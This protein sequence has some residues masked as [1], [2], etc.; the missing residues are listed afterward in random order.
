MIDDL[1][2]ATFIFGA[3]GSGKTSISRALADASRPRWDTAMWQEGRA[4]DV[5]VY[6]KDFAN[7]VIESYSRLEGVFLLGG[8]S[9]D[10]HD[11]LDEIKSPQGRQ[12]QVMRRREGCVKNLED[13]KA[14]LDVARSTFESSVWSKKSE[15][16]TALE[17]AFKGYN[18]AKD[19]FARQLLTEDS[20]TGGQT[21]DEETLLREASSIFDS[22]TGI[23]N[24]IP[25]IQTLDATQIR[26]CAMLGTRIVG[27]ADAR[28]SDLVD[29]LKN[30]DWVNQ[31]RHYLGHAKGLC[32]FC[33]QEVP[34]DLAAALEELFDRTYEDQKQQLTVFI[35]E[36]KSTAGDIVTAAESM[37]ATTNKFIDGDKLFA[38]VAEL[39][40]ADLAARTK[41]DEKFNS[42]ANGFELPNLSAQID[43]VNEVIRAANANI[44]D[45]NDRIQQ[46]SQKHPLLVKRCWRYFAKTHASSEIAVYTST[47]ARLRPKIEGL[48]KSL[49]AADEELDQISLRIQALEAQMVSSAEV[50]TRINRLLVNT[51][52]SS[53][54]LAPSSEVKDGYTMVRE[55][56]VVE[57]GTLSEGEST[58][59][60]FLYFYY[61]VE[62][63][64]VDDATRPLIVVIDDPISSM[65][66][67]AMLV[68]SVLVKTLVERTK[69]PSS[70]ISQVIVLTH[71][72]HFHKEV[73]YRR[74]LNADGKRIFYIIRKFADAPH[75]LTKHE[76]NPIQSAYGR[77]WQ[78][79]REAFENPDLHSPVGL[80]NIMRRILETYFNVL[81]DVGQDGV[82]NMF[83]GDDMLICRSLYLW[84][85]GGSH[86]L[87]DDND[88]S[89]TAYSADMY[90]RVFREIFEKTNQSQ[91]FRMMMHLPESDDVKAL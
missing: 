54:K 38:A 24:L 2:D 31:G 11:E 50:I 55:G 90:L 16:P 66:S 45:H 65:D 41:L 48:N 37:V 63:T 67:D 40:R 53:F 89:P 33:Q 68:V 28:L 81:G 25:L 51:G 72:V 59:I 20:S 13:T 22:S 8:E 58:F 26:G 32:P 42:P 10:L 17:P 1:R 23:E 9:Q 77:L 83:S 64:R 71:N 44:K 39:K 60:T 70:R 46:R 47:E 69:N 49:E 15:M 34:V 4:G 52:F 75:R 35:R 5:L 61:L 62:N 27:R 6:N 14:E 82:T 91:H 73:A 30:H 18:G 88:F 7:N 78:E 3:N 80:E 19:K 85:N 29:V 79:V 36:F 74:D 56:G 12:A 87:F 57:Q 21:D 43:S 86:S 76:K 84:A